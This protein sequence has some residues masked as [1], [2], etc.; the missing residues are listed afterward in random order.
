MGDVR[1]D[2]GQVEEL[3]RLRRIRGDGH[4]PR[5]RRQHQMLARRNRVIKI[6]TTKTFSFIP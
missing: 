5:L 2:T 6:W 1:R 3:V 4:Q